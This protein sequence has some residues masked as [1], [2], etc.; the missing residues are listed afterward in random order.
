MRRLPIRLTTLLLGLAAV[1]AA[2]AASCEALA[3]LVLPD[4]TITAAERPAGTAHCRVAGVI[5]PQVQFQVWLPDAWNGKYLGVG[6][7]ALAGYLNLPAMTKAVE[8]G[9][10]SASTDTGHVGSPIEGAWAVGRPDLVEDFGHRAIHVTTV[11]AKALVAA[12]YGTAPARSYF[13]GCSTGG[14][15]ALVAAQRYPDDFDG[16]VAGAPAAHMTRLTSL[17]NWV[18]QAVHDDPASRIPGA[19]VPA[20]AAAVLARC[21]ARDGLTDGLVSDPLR[22]RFQPQVLRCAGAETDACLTDAQIAALAKLYDGPRTS[23]GRRI[24][25]GYPPGGELGSGDEP[26]PISEPSIGGWETWLVGE[27]PGIAHFIQDAFFRFLVFEDATWDWRRFDFDRDVARTEA[28]L[29]PVMD[30]VDP[31]LRAF[32]ARG[33]RLLAFHGWSDSAIPATATVEY[34]QRMVRR[35]GGRKRTRAFA[36]LFLAPGMQHCAGG[37]GPNSFDAIGALEAWVEQGTAPARLVASHATDGVVD[38]TRPLCPW[39]E[40]ARWDRRGSIDA[41][42]SFAC[43]PPRRQARAAARY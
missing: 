21:D 20:L 6:N 35:M 30:A 28:K 33:G 13:A 15:Q 22:C 37:P 16:I 7:G 27:L 3:M 23:K 29:G 8:R 31:D 4:T 26:G 41:A 34:W 38:R 24:Y 9:Y 36:R 40:V 25:P 14:R 1:P 17:G 39:P 5:A 10:A 2:H 32:R 18:S 19:K 11:V 12:Y 42:A 43:R